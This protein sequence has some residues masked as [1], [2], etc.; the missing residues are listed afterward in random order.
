[1]KKPRLR[2][3]LPPSKFVLIGIVSTIVSHGIFVLYGLVIPP[4]ISHAIGFSVG[5]AISVSGLSWIFDRSIGIRQLG[6]YGL[7]HVLIFAMGQSAIFFV[8]PKSLGELLAT[9]VALLLV[10]STLAFFGGRTIT[11]F[12]EYD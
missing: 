7:L 9:S 8:G 3:L 10:S 12:G 6:L 2:R 4:F 5:L 11:K 1:M